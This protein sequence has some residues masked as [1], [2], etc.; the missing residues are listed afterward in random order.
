MN[1]DFA[2]TVAL[3]SCF[4]AGVV[5]WCASGT[6]FARKAAFEQRRALRQSVGA[7]GGSSAD[8][9]LHGASGA[10]VRYAM[11]LS[12]R[13][14][15]KTT[16][17]L[18]KCLRSGLL[19]RFGRRSDVWFSEH[20][21]KAGL[22]IE[23]SHRGF[24]E[25]GMRLSLMGVSVG[26][27]V[28]VVLSNELAVLLGFLG[29]VGGAISP[30]W[31]V[32]VAES[33]RTAEVERHLSEMLE[34]VALGL[35]SG[36]SFDRSFEL[37]AQYFSSPFAGACGSVQ[38]RWSLGLSTRDE[39][40]RSLAASYGS[41]Q[42]TR[43]IENIVRSLRFGSSLAEGLEAAAVEARAEHRAR[44]E[45]KVARAPVKMMMPTGALI[46]PAMLL[47]VLGPVLL[48]LGGGF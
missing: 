25:A 35:R 45:E 32:G 20:A 39:A 38:R 5:G 31:A 2:S 16:R 11:D 3:L 15:H 37:Y 34:V 26:S 23:V 30:R 41:D 28:G 33:R 4:L 43:V 8:A 42:L 47:L 46:L 27:L 14:T 18:A 24:H 36:L 22:A 10:I 40:L 19:Q 6:W 17:S 21:R 12:R 44:M 1:A 13:L 29:L 48:D 9:H 7:D